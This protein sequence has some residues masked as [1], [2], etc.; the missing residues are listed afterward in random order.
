MQ[1]YIGFK[2]LLSTMETRNYDWRKE[3]QWFEPMHQKAKSGTAFSLCDHVRGMVYAMLSSNRP[4]VG[5]EQNMDNIDAIFHHFDVDYLLTVSP[6]ELTRQITAIR[7]GNLQIKRQMESLSENIQTLQRIAADHGSID[8]YY[9]SSPIVDVVKSLGDSGRKYKLKW[10]G[11]PLVCA[12]LM[13]MG[14]DICK[15]DVHVCRIIGRLDYS[16]KSPKC[17]TN[18][19]AIKICE[20]IATEYDLLLVEVDTILWQYGVENKLGICGAEPKCSD[21][22][23]EHCSARNQ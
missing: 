21:C 22:P 13:G 2:E 20:A 7:C 6:E 15:P 16:K 14:Y 17:A 1:G 8:H 5:I 9:N 11:R 3:I 10:M 18:M 4:W 12:Y 19:E 23:V